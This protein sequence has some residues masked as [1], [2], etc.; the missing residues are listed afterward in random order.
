MRRVAPATLCETSGVVNK[1]LI[2]LTALLN[3]PSVLKCLNAVAF[4]A[5]W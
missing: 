4:Y 2:D 3:S 5:L 1:D